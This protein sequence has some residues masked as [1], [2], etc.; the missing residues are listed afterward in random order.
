MDSPEKSRKTPISSILL[1]LFFLIVIFQFK[2]Y[3][4]YSNKSLPESIKNELILLGAK[5]IENGDVPV[6]S[7]L[8]YHD[9]IIGRG[10]NTVLINNNITGHAEINAINEA[11]LKMGLKEFSNLDRKHL[12]L[13]STY[14]PCEMC[15]GT[16]LHYNI[17]EIRFMKSKTIMHW[18]KKE[19]KSI[20]Y[21]FKKRQTEG[22]SIQDSL[23]ILHPDYPGE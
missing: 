20:Y 6:G 12:T 5:A 7:V 16:I 14:E 11:M 8:V 15:K 19:A 17:K 21:E 1:F 3:A 23:F 2:F 9:S 13:Y 10:Y 18:W 22:A 4:L